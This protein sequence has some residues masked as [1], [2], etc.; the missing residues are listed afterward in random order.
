MTASKKSHSPDDLRRRVG[1]MDQIAGVRMVTLEDGNERPNR[2]AVFHTGSGLE[3]TVMLDRCLDISAAS[4]C[5]KAMGWRSVCGDVA[6]QYFEPEGFRWL[7][8][9]FGG[10][11]TTCGL[12]N[13]GGPA[14]D[15]A[16]S[17]VGLHGR[18][19]NAPARNIRVEQEWDED[20]EYMLSV[21]GT[22]REAVVFGENLTLTREVFTAMGE[23]RFW[24]QDTLTN[25]GFRRSPFMLLYHCNVGWPAVDGGSRL[26]A[27]SRRVAP[28]TDHARDGQ[29]KHNI[30]DPP[31]PDY[32]EK[33][34]YHDMEPN[35]EGEVTAAVV[36][37]D[38]FGVYVKYIKDEL[39]HFVQWKMMGEQ[40][41]VCGLEPC[42]SGVAG[43]AETEK[44]GLLEVLEPGESREFILEFGV[45]EAPEELEA[46]R[47][48]GRRIK[49][50]YVRTPLELLK[51]RKGGK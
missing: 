41:Y 10:L 31:T 38:G 36:N 48:M 50:E 44:E 17:G 35:E 34:Y 37:K 23:K 24:V 20:D 21:E 42:T 47:K 51:G 33:C 30:M 39:P 40:D 16:V 14:A 18:I 4:F 26:Y 19:G 2:A 49:T 28:V 7:R 8:S 15:S 1:N 45:I 43:R 3:F 13:V 9:Y 46:L 32:A 5:G 27:P 25:E 22:M 6:P 12:S 29:E 11:L